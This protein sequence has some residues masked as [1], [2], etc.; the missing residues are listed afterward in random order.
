[1][2]LRTKFLSTLALILGVSVLSITAAAQDTPPVP[3]K[4]R[5]M[6]KGER[7]GGKHAFGGRMR[8]AFRFRGLQG[9]D[10]TEA[11]KAQIKSILEANKPDPAIL[12]ELKAIHDA[13]KA[14][15]TITDEQKAR[16]KAI[17][18]Q[19]REKAKSVHEQILNVLTPEQKALIETRKAEIRERFRD[20]QFDRK[21]PP[22]VP[23][24][25]PKT[26]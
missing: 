20:R 13:R 17:R 6:V 7:M 5:P 21:R 9:I 16:V 4:E 12:A 1:M 8:H 23:S 10:L 24:D 3:T 15:Q 18:E 2:S 22:R 14:G 11:Q 19:Q 26:I 25:K